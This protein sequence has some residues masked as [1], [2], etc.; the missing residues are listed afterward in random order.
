LTRGSSRVATLAVVAA[1]ILLAPRTGAPEKFDLPPLPKPSRYGDVLIDR[2][3]KDHGEK[4]VRFSH[5][6]HRLHFTCRVC[7]FELDFVM[8]ANGSG[9]TEAANRKGRFCGACH[10]GTTAFGSDKT[11][12]SRCHTGRGGGSSGE[13]KS[14]KSLPRTAFGNKIDWVRAVKEGH[15]TPAQSILEEDYEPIEFTKELLLKAEWT[16]ISPAVFPHDAHQQW[17]DCANCHPDIFNIKKK[18]TAH[19]EMQ[20]NL[21]GKFCGVCHLRVAFPMDDCKRCHPQMRTVPS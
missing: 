8:E 20:Y 1:A 3:S 11:T 17:L 7:H 2:L 14:L 12:C 16:M 10:D 6:S 13:F 18:T 4:A 15:I 9:I 5:W 21:Q 19:F